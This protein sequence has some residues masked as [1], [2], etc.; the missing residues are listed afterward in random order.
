MWSSLT[1]SLLCSTAAYFACIQYL[2]YQKAWARYYL[3]NV[4]LA[5]KP[6]EEDSIISTFHKQG[7]EEEKAEKHNQAMGDTKS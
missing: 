1:T 6:F 5:Q 2:S 4:F 7:S 3:F